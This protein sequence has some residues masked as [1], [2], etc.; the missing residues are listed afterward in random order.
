MEDRVANSTWKLILTDCH[1]YNSD[2]RI[3]LRSGVEFDGYVQKHPS[4]CLHNTIELSERRGDR[5]FFINLNEIAAI[6][7]AKYV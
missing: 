6:T 5:V 3:T 7:E 4:K 2:V 1:N